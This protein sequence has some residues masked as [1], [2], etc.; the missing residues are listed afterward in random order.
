MDD[1]LG[2]TVMGPDDIDIRPWT[3]GDEGAVLALLQRSLKWTVDERPRRSS[4]GSTGTGPSV[5][6]RGGGDGRRSAGGS[7]LLAMALPAGKRGAERGS[8]RRHGHRSRLRPQRDLRRLTRGALDELQAAGIDFV[9]N[10][11]NEQSRPGYL[12][13]GWIV[14]G[15]VPTKARVRL[16]PARHRRRAPPRRRQV[17]RGCVSWL[18][19]AE[20]LADVDAQRLST[21]NSPSRTRDGPPAGVQRGDTAWTLG[22]RAALAGDSPADGLAIFRRRRGRG[23]AAVVCGSCSRTTTDAP[24]GTSSGGSRGRPTPS[25]W[26]LLATRPRGATASSPPPPRARPLT[27]RHLKQSSPAPLSD[28]RLTLGDVELF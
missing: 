2:S 3:D 26:W 4:T 6:H 22:Y 24:P 13:M 21:T 17:G 1:T 16:R 11:P 5:P 12:K 27:W 20:V 15:R 7:S 10:T 19:A 28:W 25:W 8:G 9:F 14:L 18:L 23:W